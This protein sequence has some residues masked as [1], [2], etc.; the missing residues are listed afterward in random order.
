M[1]TLIVIVLIFAIL[2]IKF[3]PRLDIVEEVPNYYR[4]LLHYSI[5]SKY[6]GTVTRNYI[7]LITFY[8]E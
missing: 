6:E 5:K 4:V 7:T 1:I 3:S 8:N 2:E